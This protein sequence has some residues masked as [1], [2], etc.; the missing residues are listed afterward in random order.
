M[1]KELKRCLDCPG[2]PSWLGWLAW[3]C[4]GFLG[5]LLGGTIGAPTLNRTERKLFFRENK[6]SVRGLAMEEYVWF[7][8][9]PAAALMI[10]TLRVEG[11]GPS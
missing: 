1:K 4:L 6:T 9:L 2:W 8:G 11:P 10:G 3:L 5:R 7:G